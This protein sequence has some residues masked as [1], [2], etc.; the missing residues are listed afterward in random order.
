[1]KALPLFEDLAEFYNGRNAVA[2]RIEK[3]KLQYMH[4]STGLDAAI[5]TW[6]MQKFDVILTGN[7]GDGKTHLISILQNRDSLST[8]YLEKD[9][10]Q[11]DTETILKIWQQKKRENKPFVLAINQAPLRYLAEKALAYSGLEY[12]ANIP[13]EIDNCT[14]Y[15]DVPQSKLQRTIVV[16]LS[17]REI[18]TIT[19]VKGIVDRLCKQIM[20]ARCD[21]CP[22]RRCPVEYNASALSNDEILHNLVTILA[23]VARRGFHAT[24]RDLIGL[25]AYILTGDKPCAARWLPIKN[26]DGDFSTPT[27][28]DYVYYTLLFKGRSRLFDAI[29]TT[30][31]PANYSDPDSD[32]KLCAG[33]IRDGWSVSDP[34]VILPDSLEELRTL[35]RRYFF[36]HRHDT[37]KLLQ[38][39]LPTTEYNFGALIKGELDDPSEVENLVD[40]INNFYAPLHAHQR[41]DQRYRL[42]LWNSH[43][44]S[45]GNRPGYF[46]MRSIP[47]DNLTIY[48]P[49]AI[50][51]IAQAMEIRQDHV[52][53]AVQNWVPGD[54]RLRLDWPIYQALTSAHYGTPIEV[55]PFHILRRLDL[56]LRSLGPEA[57]GSRHVENIEWSDHQHRTPV[58]IRVNRTN[59]SYEE[60]RH[61]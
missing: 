22:P 42:R 54:P 26:E 47:A 30:F 13:D 19:L 10:S 59:Q 44:Y 37:E 4:I 51:Q 16:D 39:M 11:K 52:L 57:G 50:P 8:A 18:V 55:Q 46:A 20:S 58:S 48:R 17:R 56:F 43:R 33:A 5:E 27:F 28:E 1:M 29:R 24:M 31:D 35:K 53:L 14:Y 25:I 41:T 2:E 7:P 21:D 15:N 6:V 49:K 40:M 12:L 32:A 60:E 45:V 34:A 36:E 61:A 23:L 38:R 3:S 9:A